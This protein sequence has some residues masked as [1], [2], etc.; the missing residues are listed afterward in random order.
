M[1]FKYPELLYALFLLLIPIFI[2]LF[3]LRRFQKVDFTNVAFLKKVTL[4]TRKSSQLKKW[5][6]LLMRMLALASII[7]AFA[8]P[9]T[10]S[11][12]ALNTQKE[13]IIYIDNSFSMQAKGPQGPLLQR[14]AQDLFEQISPL[15]K[16]SWFTN[17]FDRKNVSLQD[18][19]SEI[20]TLD[21]SQAQLSPEEVLLKANRLFSTTNG[22]EKRLIYISD[23]QLKSEFPKVQKEISIDA[24]PVT[25]ILA[26]NVLIDT[27]Y[28][29]S[30]TSENIKLN[31]ELISYGQVSTDIPVSLFKNNELIAKSGVN[32]ADSPS[33]LITFD[34]ENKDDFNGRFELNE[35]NLPFDNTLYFC[36]NT[37][38]KINILSINDSPSNYI[39]RLFDRPEFNYLQQT[40][41]NINYN[42]IP[43]QNFI[44]L[45][46]LKNIP[47][48]LKTALESFSS[49]GGSLLVIPSEESVLEEYNSLLGAY[50]MGSLSEII[51]EERKITKIVFDHP[52]YKDV[53][54]K[55]VLNFQYPKVNS[56][57]TIDSKSTP[58]LKFDDDSAFMIQSD[59]MYLCT[60]PINANNSNFQN[61]PLIVPTLYNMAQQSL[62]SPKLYYLIGQDNTFSV[63]IQLMQDEIL[64][65]QDSLNSFIP[66]QQVKPKKV[67]ISTF[68]EPSRAG[69]YQIKQEEQFIE[70]ISYNYARDESIMQY[71]NPEDWEGVTTYS[72]IE[73]LF[74]TIN[75]VN[76]INSFWKWFAIFAIVFLILEMLILKY[77]K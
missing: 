51:K 66:L 2:H 41:N 1:Q 9:F 42:L 26:S 31:V 56:Y 3:Q 60:G 38:N 27:A 30:K 16:I 34:I 19:K 7:I 20:L 58:I 8:Q 13:T 17:D 75:E 65:I 10:A 68:D 55:R 45:N 37:P 63:P 18:F 24:I 64:K 76:S 4:Q 22:I 70:N 25:P 49:N 15:D 5:L 44:I 62:P 61:S 14:A 23:F 52:L 32:F 21:Y 73:E 33:A 46:E 67:D 48:S 11:K 36:I 39:Q 53:F 40:S 72:T 71:A 54:E 47:S 12:S 28:I 50:S 57:Y 69:T 35:A 77:Y 29:V 74:D 59:H 43:D 6:T